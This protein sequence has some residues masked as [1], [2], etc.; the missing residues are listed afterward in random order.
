LLPATDAAAQPFG[1]AGQFSLSGERLSGVVVASEST[2]EG[3][4]DQTTTYTSVSLLAS[5]LAATT[6]YSF[7]RIGLDYLVTD[8]FTIGA[9]LGMFT[10]SG[11]AEAEAMGQSMEEDLGSFLGFLFAPRLGYAYMFNESVGIWPRGGITYATLKSENDDPDITL[12][13]NR[14]ALSLD[15]PLVLSPVPH[16]GILLGP[17][18]DFGVSGSNEAEVGGMSTDTDFKSTDFGLHAGLMA[19]F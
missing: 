13:Q 6:N 4:V 10:V 14:L 16:V 7:P 12:S 19:Y 5:P 1:T 17:A 11:T 8:G 18:I 9:A 2:D 3:G 15:V